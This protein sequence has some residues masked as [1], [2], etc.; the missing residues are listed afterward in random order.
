MSSWN[1][2]RDLADCLAF[3]RTSPAEA[4]AILT[5]GFRGLE[6]V[7]VSLGYPMPPHHRRITVPDDPDYEVDDT[8]VPR[9]LHVGRHVRRV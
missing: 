1:E 3:Y 5:N 7:W 6:E 2:P 8:I 4:R 9:V